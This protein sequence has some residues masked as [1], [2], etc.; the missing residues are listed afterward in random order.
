M[1][2]VVFVNHTNPYVSQGTFCYLPV[3]PIW[4]RL[5]LAWVPRY[6]IFGTIVG[7]Y[8]AIYIYVKYKFKGVPVKVCDSDLAPQT[9]RVSID[10]EQ[11]PGTNSLLGKQVI[12]STPVLAT[13]GLTDSTEELDITNNRQSADPPNSFTPSTTQGNSA[14]GNAASTAAPVWENYTFGARAVLGPPPRGGTPLIER[15]RLQAV[16]ESSEASNSPQSME[17]R[18]G[19]VQIL[20]ES[21]R[22]SSFDPL[23]D[24]SAPGSRRPTLS[25]KG[26]RPIDLLD[27]NGSNVATRSL[28]RR[29]IAI[30][31]QLRY[32]FTYP[33]VYILMWFLP[34]LGHCLNYSDHYSRYP[35][36]GI[37][38]CIVVIIPLQCAVDC[39][40][41][42]YREKPWQYIPGS[43]GTFWN[44]FAFWTHDRQGGAGAMP[45]ALGVGNEGPWRSQREMSA[46]SILAY[47]RREEELGRLT[48]SRVSRDEESRSKKSSSAR[49][50][51]GGDLN[52]WEEEGRLRQDSV[53]MGTEGSTKPGRSERNPAIEE[54]DETSEGYTSD[55]EE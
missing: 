26:G 16:G 52:W 32:M 25:S 7:I 39:W 54:E 24:G 1:A 10:D 48:A 40:L 36:Y 18:I 49:S 13:H 38:C 29:Q 9:S 5:A 45:P 37:N 53:W 14:S 12:P 33:T 34:F 47:Q 28:R 55:D 42:A 22:P 20:Q 31:R 51:R 15:P 3:R 8:V 30:H 2:S 44:S 6:V 17:R 21:R 35:M 46:D 41:F 27:S 11:S 50:G 23:T 19:L 43:R 4:F